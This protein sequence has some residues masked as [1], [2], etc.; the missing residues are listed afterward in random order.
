MSSGKKLLKAPTKKMLQER[1]E[2]QESQGGGVPMQVTMGMLVFDQN[3]KRLLDVLEGGEIKQ[4]IEAHGN[5]TPNQLKKQYAII[6]VPIIPGWKEQVELFLGTNSVEVV[7]ETPQKNEVAE[8][9]YCE[10]KEKE[11]EAENSMSLREG[12]D[13]PSLPTLETLSVE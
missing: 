8:K 3:S 1:L 6:P 13:T 12:E 2:K 11:T 9:I 5:V 7:E 4:W 10:A